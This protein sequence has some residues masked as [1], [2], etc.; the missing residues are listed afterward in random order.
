ML[1]IQLY[2]DFWLNQYLMFALLWLC[3]YF[4]WLSYM[5]YNY[6]ILFLV[7]Y[8]Y[9]YRYIYCRNNVMCSSPVSFSQENRRWHLP[10]SFV[11]QLG[12]CDWVLANGN[13]RGSDTVLISPRLS[14]L[15]DSPL[16]EA[17]VK[18]TEMVALQDG[19]RLGS[20][21]TTWRRAA[22]Q[23]QTVTWMRY[24]PLCVKPLRF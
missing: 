24:K 15:P 23:F 6:Y 3:K 13:A 4:P 12:P 16:Q 8:R 22:N 9:I 17:G 18:G 10:A 14:P 21:V 7:W 2:C 11:V 5:R 20:W 1:L 19:R